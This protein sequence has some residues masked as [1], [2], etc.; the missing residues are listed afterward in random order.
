MTRQHHVDGVARVVER[1]GTLVH[2]HDIGI[3]CKHLSDGTQRAPVGHRHG[4]RHESLGKL[5]ILGL[6][7]TLLRGDPIGIHRHF[8]GWQRGKHRVDRRLDVAHHGSCYSTVYVNLLGVDVN[9][10]ELAVG[11]PLAVTSRQQPVEACA[12]EHHHIGLFHEVTAHGVNAQFMIVGQQT[13]GHRHLVERHS[14]GFDKLPDL[15]VDLSI[16]G[17][18]SKQD[19]GLLGP[20]QQLHGPCHRLRRR[21]HRRTQVDR[22]I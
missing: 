15:V 5:C 11:I 12:Y 9:L 13:L 3:G 6:R 17:S 1:I 14:G 4:L 19:D 7:R 8:V 20:G 2:K 22:S 18:L 21:N 16:G 10:D